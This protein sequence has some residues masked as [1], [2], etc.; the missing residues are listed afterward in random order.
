MKT[1]KEIE[2]KIR[3]EATH[4][5]TRGSI[6]ETIEEEEFLHED[7][8]S[9]GVILVDKG[10]NYYATRILRYDHQK[11][12]AKEIFHYE[13]INPLDRLLVSG[14]KKRFKITKDLVI[15]YRDEVK[16]KDKA[17]IEVEE[18]KNKLSEMTNKKEQLASQI[19]NLEA[20]KRVGDET[21]NNL[22]QRISQLINELQSQK[23][24]SND[25]NQQLKREL[26]KK[27]QKKQNLEQQSSNNRKF[28]DEFENASQTIKKLQKN[29]SQFQRSIILIG[30]TGN[31]KSTL[32]NVLT[33]TNKFGK[34][35]YSTSQTTEKQIEEF[36]AENGMKYRVIDTVGIGDTKLS[37]EDVLKGIREVAYKDNYNLN[38]I[39]FVFEGKFEDKEIEAFNLLKNNIFNEDITKYITLVRTKFDHYEDERECE[40]EIE[41]LK[42]SKKL[43]K[44]INSCNK[45]IHVNNPPVNG[46]KERNI[47]RKKILNHL[48]T[49]QENY[50]SQDSNSEYF[51]SSPVQDDK[52][53]ELTIENK[54]IIYQIKYIYNQQQFEKGKK[55][56]ELRCQALESTEAQDNPL[57]DPQRLKKLILFLGAKQRFAF[58]RQNTINKLI[59]I[60]NKS[61]K[62]DKKYNKVL[63]YVN[64]SGESVGIVSTGVAYPI[65]FLGKAISIVA[66]IF[67]GK[68]FVDH[69]KKFEEYL[70]EDENDV[71]FLNEKYHS[72]V[73]SFKNDQSKISSVIKEILEPKR[74]EFIQY[75]VFELSSIQKEEKL[76]PEKAEEVIKS[77]TDHLK[78]FEK[79]IQQEVNQ[80][81][82][83]IE[84]VFKEKNSKLLQDEVKRLIEEL[85]RKGNE[86]DQTQN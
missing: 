59:E 78:K 39:L 84:K 5:V 69:G 11:D 3:K 27:D 67:K 70:T 40:T 57:S 81:S 42:D 83:D 77:L 53:Q 23:T 80:Y 36:T 73:D 64:I 46:Q 85:N 63:E 34:G 25:A 17:L 20:D 32:A 48:L 18:L 21:I 44:I 24:N 13:S 50:Q 82:E 79:E 31:G 56:F 15:R 7:D 76:T 47:S 19:N 29:L 4:S 68:S 45:L 74:N 55:E 72:L 30:R 22:R 37:T 10:A 28:F 16:N 1:R 54:N 14:A 75:S 6:I 51:S 58:T 8:Y 65:I 71:H 41:K 66:E 52:R 49:C 38:Q 62:S 26:P 2:T 60:Y 43:E 35:K 33:G 9:L 61:K 86:N 12:K